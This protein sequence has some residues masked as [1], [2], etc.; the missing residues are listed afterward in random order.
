VF[1]EGVPGA[2]VA[3]VR[4]HGRVA[5]AYQTLGPHVR[6][7]VEGGAVVAY[8]RARRGPGAGR[9]WVAAGEPLAPLADV[10][11]AARA[12]EAEAR[13]A[14][15]SV[16]W[17]GVERPERLGGAHDA[18]VAGAQPV[19]RPARWPGVMSSKASLRAQVNRARNKG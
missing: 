6:H 7:W 12:F 19:W 5:S 11:G 9:V 4:Q 17:F 10:A 13:R 15:A 2:A 1:P 16:V 18:L 14:G 3:A 8:A